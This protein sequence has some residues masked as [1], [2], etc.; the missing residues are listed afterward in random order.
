MSPSFTFGLLLATFYGALAHL[1]LGGGGRRLLFYI[2][3]AWVGF[4]LGQAI[5]EVME[6]QILAI[7]PTNVLAATL[8]SVVALATTA[9]LSG[10]WRGRDDA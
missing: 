10:Q 4:A 9:V 1:I 8:G 2:L 5:G 6:I 7:G 3:A